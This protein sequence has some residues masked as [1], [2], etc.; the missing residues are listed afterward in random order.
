MLRIKEEAQSW[1]NTFIQQF[2]QII[3]SDICEN[4]LQRP[5]CK[6]CFGR[7]QVIKNVRI[8]TKGT[9]TSQTFYNSCSNVYSLA[10]SLQFQSTLVVSI[11]NLMV[12]IST[13]SGLRFLKA[14]K[15]DPKR[16]EKMYITITLLR[17]V[18][19]DHSQR[20]ALE[21][22]LR[23]SDEFPRFKIYIYI[24]FIIYGSLPI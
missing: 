18:F 5:N 6:I 4:P 9:V 17:L 21:K 20:L 13:A 7:L 19:T 3:P 12:I 22:N 16:K 2:F 8:W 14:E 1:H 11:S 24:Y 23:G 10:K 15:K